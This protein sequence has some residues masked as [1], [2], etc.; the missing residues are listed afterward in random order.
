[1][2]AQDFVKLRLQHESLRSIQRATGLTWH[3]VLKLA[4]ETEDMMP[5]FHEGSVTPSIERKACPLPEGNK[6]NRYILTCAQNNT[7]IHEPF[8]RNLLGYAQYLGAEVMVS[9]I[10]YNKAG[11]AFHNGSSPKTK[12]KNELGNEVDKIMWDPAIPTSMLVTDRI[13]LA[14]TLEFCGETD[15]N[16]TAVNPLSGMQEY[17]KQASGIIPHTKRAMES[18]ATMK[19]APCKFMYTTGTITKRN[20]IGRKAGQRA[21]FHHCFGAL[22][23]EV[24]SQG[25]WWCRQITAGQDGS[26]YDLETFVERDGEELSAHEPEAIILGDIHAEKKDP[27]VWLTTLTMIESL[28]PKALVV[29]D[30]VDFQ[31]CSPHD[32]YNHGENFKKWMQG[33]S[34]VGS[35]ITQGE[36]ALADI[37]TAHDGP[38]YVVESNHDR[39]LDRWLDFADYRYDP[40]NA[41]TFLK[42]QTRRYEDYA[43][44][45]DDRSML[46][47]AMFPHSDPRRPYHF[48]SESDSLVIQDIECGIHG[49]LGPNGSRG[50]TRALSKIGPKTFTGHTHSAGIVGA[51][52]TVGLTA[53]LDMGY[54]KGPSSWSHTHGIIYPD[55]KRCLVTIPANR[56]GKWRA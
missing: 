39:W 23:V 52:W 27:K 36:V 47:R 50:S 41:I 14:P 35:A 6:V 21:E 49:D 10:S 12:H 5:E 32:R 20:Y 44:G 15:I 42:L 25:D 19:S 45:L 31:S 18:I 13:V 51:C 54:N 48:I 53:S 3:R 17:T 38:I 26:F 11:H 40:Q 30:L 4:K 34:S 37:T 16:P 33:A 22:I 8:F 46:E 9:P 7:K 43:S 24:D 29:H 56:K 2:N 55:G 1:M 28:Q